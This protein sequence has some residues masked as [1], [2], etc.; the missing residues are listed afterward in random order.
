MIACLIALAAI[1][2]EATFESVL[3]E[4]P[5]LKTAYS[6]KARLQPI[7]RVLAQ[8]SEST[9]QRLSAAKPFDDLKVTYSVTDRSVAW[10]L[11]R[12]ADTL[13]LTWKKNGSDFVLDSSPEAK[14]ALT[15][16]QATLD[17]AARADFQE[18]LG[19][20][21]TAG[22]LNFHTEADVFAKLNQSIDAELEARKPGWSERVRSLREEVSARYLLRSPADYVVGR[23]ANRGALG[24][25]TANPRVF[26]ASTLD[27]PGVPR[28]SQSDLA[29]VIDRT[30]GDVF[31]AIRGDAASID[32]S[33]FTFS[34]SGPNSDS[35]SWNGDSGHSKQPPNR[36]FVEWASSTQTVTNKMRGKTV[37]PL[38]L[39][40]SRSEATVSDALLAAAADCGKD[41]VADAFA[42][43]YSL[44]GSAEPAEQ[45]WTRFGRPEDYRGSVRIIDNAILFRHSGFWDFRRQEVPDR[46]VGATVQAWKRDGKLSTRL[47]AEF[48]DQLTPRQRAW[49]PQI[50][51]GR[52]PFMRIGQSLFYLDLWKSIPDLPRANLMEHRLIPLRELSRATN[53]ALRE[54]VIANLATGRMQFN[55]PG[56]KLFASLFGDRFDEFSMLWEPLTRRYEV[57]SDGNVRVA[58][59]VE[60]PVA[61]PKAVQ[62]ERMIQ[63]YLGLSAT[64]SFVAYGFEILGPPS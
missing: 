22:R 36:R 4:I 43:S 28:L 49:L 62:T 31:L 33:L 50:A 24:P 9:G 64:N 17:R 58:V 48:V 6:G 32:Y 42:I 20:L 11:D 40:K 30:A 56:S 51:D 21:K 34:S 41:L 61:D 54:Q 15:E 44:Q 52:L 63:L 10:L 59:P 29:S 7:E 53:L 45:F 1:Q 38:S 39:P 46:L 25:F 19:R 2:T 55:G 16:T 27:L 3:A 26:A 12:I 60:Q 23:L 35:G 37:N 47:Q 57:H 5:A 18:H 14:K 8:F 13:D